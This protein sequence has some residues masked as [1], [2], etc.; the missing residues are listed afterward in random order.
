MIKKR[1]ILPILVI[2]ALILSSCTTPAVDTPPD[3][4]NEKPIEETQQENPDKEITEDNSV[5]AYEDIKLTPAEAFDIYIEKYPQ[6]KVKDLEL[7]TDYGS[8]IYKVKGYDGGKE[9]K[10]YINPIDGTIIKEKE[11][12]ED[13]NSGEIT[14]ATVDKV[15]ALVDKTFEEV[16]KDAILDE[17]SLEIDDGIA[18]LEIEIDFKNGDDDIEYKYNAETGE[19]L[20][21]DN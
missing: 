21:I 8:Y 7:D 19:L 20:K 2:F 18:V 12:N 1:W 11:D 15:Q 4:G 3:G 6:T 9:Y 16:G 5:V 17:W 14:K 13:D 10:V